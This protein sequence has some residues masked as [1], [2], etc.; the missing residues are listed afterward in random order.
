MVTTNFHTHTVYCDGKDT[1]EEMVLAAIGKGFTILGFSGHSYFTRHEGVSMSVENELV[2]NQKIEELKKKYAGKIQIFRGIE[3]DYFSDAPTIPYDYAIGSV[4]CILKDGRYCDIDYSAEVSKQ[5][6]DTVYGGD[7]DGFA[8]DYFETVSRV[9]EKTN[10]DIIGHIDLV[11]KYSE[12]NGYGQSERFLAA[13]ERC[14]EKLIPYGKP[15]EINTGAMS[16]GA[17]S[18]PYPTKE[19]LTMIY[20]KGGKIMI[21]SDC[22]NK[23]YL[24]HGFDMAVQLAKD[25]GF[26]EHA[27]LTENGIEYFPL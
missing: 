23:D 13:A 12:T 6:V 8:E 9:L 26:T 19:I 20:Q 2:Y 11:S 21:N 18:I 7:F 10:A 22:H 3:L 16:R 25:C 17:R 14:V 15:F 24:N 27:V 1:P 5:V 4:H